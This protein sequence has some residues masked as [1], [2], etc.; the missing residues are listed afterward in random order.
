MSLTMLLGVQLTGCALVF[1]GLLA[2]RTFG[3]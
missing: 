1:V 3:L 2:R